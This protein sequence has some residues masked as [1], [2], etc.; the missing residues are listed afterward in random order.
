MQGKPG[1]I[2]E[3]SMTTKTRT[4]NRLCRKFEILKPF[5]RKDSVLNTCDFSVIQISVRE[6][7]KKYSENQN[8]TL[9]QLV[10]RT[11]GRVGVAAGFELVELV[12]ADGHGL[13]TMQSR[14]EKAL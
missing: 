14:S 12:A 9:H 6:G 10:V 5:W 1:T 4:T 8:G 11:K 7:G 13:T 3:L 2:A